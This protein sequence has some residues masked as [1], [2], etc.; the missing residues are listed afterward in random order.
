MEDIG[1]KAHAAISE[2]DAS[3]DLAGGRD[4]KLAVKTIQS[5]LP[6]INKGAAEGREFALQQ[7]VIA[8]EGEARLALAALLG[9]DGQRDEAEN[10]RGNACARLDQL[11]EASRKIAAGSNNPGTSE[12]RLLFSIDDEVPLLDCSEFRNPTLLTERLGWPQSLQEKI[13]KL[14]KSR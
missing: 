3:I 11:Q 13:L 9:S 14:E 8:K 1:D 12:A 5:I 10:I 6:K 2:V 4:S 7:R